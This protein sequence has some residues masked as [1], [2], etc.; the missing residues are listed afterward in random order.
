[1]TGLFTKILEAKTAIEV[2]RIETENIF[3]L[4]GCQR[5]KLHQ[6]VNNRKI[7]LTNLV[8]LENKIWAE[9]RN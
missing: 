2:D 8:R 5:A 3:K 9:L 7:Y 6:I 4:P 1:M